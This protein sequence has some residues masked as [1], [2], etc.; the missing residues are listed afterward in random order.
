MSTIEV[1]EDKKTA[2][3]DDDVCDGHQN[4]RHERNSSGK[5]VQTWDVLARPLALAIIG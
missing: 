3:D 4:G 5:R 2:K 1:A